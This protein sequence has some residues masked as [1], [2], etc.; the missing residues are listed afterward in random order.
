MQVTLSRKS[1]IL[2]VE[3]FGFRAVPPS[4]PAR[5]FSGSCPDL[6]G[7]TALSSAGPPNG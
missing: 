6:P 1:P 4:P 5:P 7:A 3:Q 2:I